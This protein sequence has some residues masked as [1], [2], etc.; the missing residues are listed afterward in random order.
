VADPVTVTMPLELPA[1]M[2]RAVRRHP[3]T[4]TDDQ[5]EENR[6]IG[7]LICAWDVMVEYQRCTCGV[8]ASHETKENDRG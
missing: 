6:R 2:L 3:L 1:A 7:W 5:D 4:S 8:P